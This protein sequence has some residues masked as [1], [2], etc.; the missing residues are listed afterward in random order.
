MDADAL[1]GS[2]PFCDRHRSRSS[3]RFVRGNGSNV[4]K[5]VIAYPPM[6]AGSVEGVI[7]TVRQGIRVLALYQYQVAAEFSDGISHHS[8]R[9]DMT[10]ALPTHRASADNHCLAGGLNTGPN[11]AHAVGDWRG[12]MSW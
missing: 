3:A 4:V 11:D 9:L 12:P 6:T 1:A 8:T 10:A 7:R 5:L 2:A